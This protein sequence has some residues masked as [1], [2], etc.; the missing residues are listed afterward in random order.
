MGKF[1][2]KLKAFSM[3]GTWRACR[4]CGKKVESRPNGMVNCPNCGYMSY[5]KSKRIW[6][7]RATFDLFD[8]D[9]MTLM[10]E[11]QIEQLIRPIGLSWR[12]YMDTLKDMRQQAWLETYKWIKN[13]IETSVNSHLSGK[14][15]SF[16]A[17]KIDED[18]FLITKIGESYET[19]RTPEIGAKFVQGNLKD[20]D[21]ITQEVLQSYSQNLEWWEETPVLVF[22]KLTQGITIEIGLRA[23]LQEYGKS[24]RVW[25]RANGTHMYPAKAVRTAKEQFEWVIRIYHTK[26]WNEHL[27]EILEYCV[28]LEERL[29]AVIKAAEQLNVS[30]I[31]EIIKDLPENTQEEISGRWQGGNLWNLV[32]IAGR[33][34]RAA[35]IFILKKHKLLPED[36]AEP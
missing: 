3:L 23:P 25:M 28:S 15:L 33:I 14:V 20:L 16:N 4:K 11:K 8:T 27:R 5:K 19:T 26:G 7:A 29:I 6:V 9:V 10:T 31:Q 17:K 30:S 35:A 34:D 1:V 22:K 24:Y 2:G 18:T 21:A 36:E 13:Q 32:Q 12:R